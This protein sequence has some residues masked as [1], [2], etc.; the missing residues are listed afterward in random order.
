VYVQNNDKVDVQ[1]ANGKPVTVVIEAGSSG[2][3]AVRNPWQGSQVQV[4]SDGRRVGQPTADDT[5]HVR[6]DKG[7]SYLIE[8]V[9]APTTSLP[10]APVTG[11]AATAARHLG[12]VQIGL[13]PSVPYPSLAASFNDPGISDDQATNAGNYDGNDAS[14][15]AE[16]LA[17]AGATPGASITSAGVTFTW[18]DVA[19]GTPDNT[20]AD[21]QTID[22]TGTG[23][24]VGFL[25]SGSSGSV[26]GTGQLVYTD[27]TVS[28]YTI[29]SPDWFDTNPPSGGTVAVAS[30]YQNRPGNTTYVHSADVFAVP[31]PITAGKT[32]AQVI[33]PAVG[34]LGV[35]V[36][37]LH[38]FAI[39]IG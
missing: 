6:L 2:T 17:A 23:G 20:V 25:V 5:L 39:G 24:K 11:T 34:Q 21:G 10:F 1:V 13:D 15:S 4:V 27:G 7:N 3:I 9:A 28:S 18:P 16:A 19:A 33:L 14:F 38:V 30:T 12:P 26:S 31:V 29:T 32:V 22:I 35:G 36:P 37:S 8:P